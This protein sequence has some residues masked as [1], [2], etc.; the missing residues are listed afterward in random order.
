[1]RIVTLEE[2][3]TIPSLVAQIPKELIRQR[4]FSAA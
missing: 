2:H 1:M 4:G 3:F